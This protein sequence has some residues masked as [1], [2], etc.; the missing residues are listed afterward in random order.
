MLDGGAFHLAEVVTGPPA[1]GPTETASEEE[2]ELAD[3]SLSIKIVATGAVR[4]V[5]TMQV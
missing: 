5:E 4:E 3:A 2:E 1:V